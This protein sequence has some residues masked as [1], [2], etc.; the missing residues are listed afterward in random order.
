[1]LGCHDF[2]GYYEWTFH[3]LRRRF[4][5]TGLEKYW[6]QAIASDSQLHYVAAAHNLGLRGLYESW[7]K[8]GGDEHCDWS[9]TLD[10]NRN[11]VR[12]DMRQCP[13]KGFLLDNDLNADEDY[14][15]HCIGW[16]GPAL[17]QAG[18]EVAAHEH[19]HCGQCWWEIRAVNANQPPVQVECDIRQDPRW[20]QGYLHRFTHHNKLPLIPESELSDP[21]DVLVE[22]FRAADCLAV[23]GPGTTEDDARVANDPNVA[24]I[25]SGEIYAS[26]SYPTR[27]LGGVLLEHDP[28]LLAA[29][30]R[31]F[32]SSER[33]PLLMHPYLPHQPF[34]NFAEH[35]LPRAVPILPLLIRSGLY[36]HEAGGPQPGIYTF[37]VMLAAALQKRIL[38]HGIDVAEPARRTDQGPAPTTSGPSDWRIAPT[39]VEHLVRAVRH[40]QGRI[41]C[42]PALHALLTNE[43][44]RS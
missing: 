43:L 17:D 22:W 3:Y 37:A 30:A 39:D 27:R 21:C 33:R 20:G 40:V 14:C 24:V 7:S 16:I 12:L 36:T 44:E 42:P 6:A 18:F 15:D 35:G 38:L 10:E 26:G 32:V 8:T 34:L 29:V 28:D 25:V 2:C 23:L 1:V 4:G 13:S 5:R 11:L 9:V 31:R 19:N 41:E